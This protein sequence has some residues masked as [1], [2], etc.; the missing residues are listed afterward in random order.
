M[1]TTKHTALAVTALATLLLAGCGN[2]GGD[3]A[4]KEGGEAGG[5]GAPA[6][7]ATQDA[8]AVATPVRITAAKQDIVT[9]T[10]PVTGSVSALQTVDLSAK[11]AGRVVSVE[12]REGTRVSKGEIIVQQDTSDLNNQLQ[13][14]QA[15]LQ[16]SQAN[17]RTAQARLTQAETQARLQVS[18]SNIGVRDAEEQLRAAQAQLALAKQPQ[19][20][21]EVAVAENAVKQAQANYDKAK[22]D[23]ERYDNLV[24][25][26]AAAQITLDQ[27]INQ[28]RVTKAAL[29]SAQQ[30]L[31]IAKTGGRTESIQQS[32]AEVARA[33]AAVRLAKANKGQID[34]RQD[35][36]KAARAAVAQA[37]ATIAQNQ[38]AIRIAQQAVADAA[39]RSPIDGVVATRSTE[40][41]QMAAPGTAVMQLVALNTVFFEAQVPETNLSS[42]KVD[43]PVVV[44]LDAYPGKTFT[45]K[46]ARIY[47]TGS[48]SSRTFNVRVNLPNDTGMLRP[49]L[50]ARGEVIAERR[51]GT[52]VPKDAVI[53]NEGKFTVFVANNN[54]TAEQ[55]DVKVGVQTTDTT[56][57]VSGVRPGEQVIVAGQNTLK[58]GGKIDIKT[59]SGA[60][61]ETQ[62]ASL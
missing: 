39:I 3:A 40:P 52:V 22:S 44:R 10:V 29:D 47:P 12:G 20:S 28:E 2:K 18:T 61:G 5:G 38:A 42:I 26:G 45:G 27:Y 56:E 49:G 21:Q 37:N 35:D 17:L 46:V 6:A 13:Q 19:R 53:S 30:Q 59:G 36:I 58:D 31:D 24:K 57:I 14:A 51:R 4:K 33:Q 8:A 55:R 32:Q 62:Q 16:A 9:R 41:G 15:N 60:Q 1:R 50:F 48:T 54:G 11:I 34:V 43:Q 7:G 23:R 25:E